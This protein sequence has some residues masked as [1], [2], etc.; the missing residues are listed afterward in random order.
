MPKWL[1]F[2][3]DAQN[4]AQNGGKRLCLHKKSKHSVQ[5]DAIVFTIQVI[6]GHSL[7]TTTDRYMA[8]NPRDS[9]SLRL[10]ECI[11]LLTATLY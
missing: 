8:D 10:G 4:D 7:S 5:W 3:L 6:F 9:S 1:N 11:E 2:T